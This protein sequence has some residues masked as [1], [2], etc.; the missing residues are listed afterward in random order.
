MERSSFFNAELKGEEYDRVYLAE[1]YA[2]Y[3]ASFI[4]NGIFPTP[5][6]NLQVT[7]DGTTMN[8]I[9][10]QGK[11]W[12]NGY[13]YENTEDLILSID[14]ADGVLNRIDRVVVRLDF[15]NR[16][17]KTYV[18]KGAFASSPVTPNLTRNADMYELGIADIRINK[19]VTKI[20][21]ADITDLRQ[22]NNYCGLVA[23]VVQQID[24][25]NL[26]TQFQSSFDIWFEHIKGQLSTDQAGNL[27]NQIDLMNNNKINFTDII[28]N[29]TSGGVKKVL[30]AEQ[31]KILKGLIDEKA[32]R[33]SFIKVSAGTGQIAQNG[34]ITKIQLQN[35]ID[36]S[37]GIIMSNYGV[38]VPENC[39]K[40]LVEMCSGW[41]TGVNGDLEHRLHIAQTTADSTGS[42]QIQY[43]DGKRT[44]ANTSIE[45]IL[46]SCFT[47]EGLKAGNVLYMNV[48][49]ISGES[50]I[51][52][53]ITYMRVTFYH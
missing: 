29:L 8:I 36:R 27:Q 20:V 22:N 47:V 13:F 24:T 17:I 9:L 21:Q 45:S 32:N 43:R 41:G 10:K 30:S 23:G 42:G 52:G 34:Q 25:T 18:K 31:G 5:S 37:P 6:T 3:F 48:V 40:A 15:I 1:D 38:V 50:R 11:A 53:N 16:E 49:Q 51:I 28:N 19:G 2:R 44:P 12:I 14:V 33:T 35:I 46:H 39:N 7:A 4:G 26:F